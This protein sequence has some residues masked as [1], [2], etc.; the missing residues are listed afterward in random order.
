MG[1]KFS[2]GL[3]ARQEIMYQ[4]EKEQPVGGFKLNYFQFITFN[5]T[6]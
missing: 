6:T 1:L 2:S 3:P 4:Q 5:K